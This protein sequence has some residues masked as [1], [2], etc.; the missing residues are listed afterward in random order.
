MNDY[1]ITPSE[2]DRLGLPE[3]AAGIQFTVYYMEQIKNSFGGLLIFYFSNEKDMSK[4]GP[5]D[6]NCINVTT[7]NM[8]KKKQNQYS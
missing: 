4:A 1:G 6:A 8:G 2:D 3:T 7:C 5:S